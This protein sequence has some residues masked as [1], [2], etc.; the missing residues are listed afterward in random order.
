[1][2]LVLLLL[3]L[4]S[5]IVYRLLKFWILDP[6]RIHRDLWSQG[7]PGRYIPVVG[8]ILHIRKRI[9]AE[10]PFSHGRA[11]ATRS[12]DY[13]HISFGPIARF[14]TF[15]PALMNG[16]LK[17]NAHAYHKPYIMQMIL[18][19]LLGNDS[20]LMSED[21]VHARH[22][23]LIAP[24]FQHQNVNSMISLMAEIT[25]NLITK[26]AVA[27]A[28]CHK[29]EP[30]TLNIREEMARLTLDNVSVTSCVFGTEIISDE[31]I[32]ETIYRGA[33]ETLELVE[34]RTFNMIGII[35]II[36]RLPF[37]GKPH[38]DKCNR[39]TKEIIRRIVDERKKGL[40]KSACKG[41]RSCIGQNFAMLEAKIMLA[42]I[43]RRFRFELEPGQKYVPDVVI[44]MRLD[45]VGLSFNL[46]PERNREYK[47]PL[48]HSET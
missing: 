1:M 30:F 37:A 25:S 28:A 23:R 33:T 46:E 38:I 17:T 19:V 20:L 29:D 39:E 18:G 24:V 42:L 11:L 9:L 4:I 40:T 26:W 7:V 34:K 21:E 47:F 6:W 3:A 10:D 8:E 13:Y 15:D 41:P 16:V 2:L 5:W 27:A 43:I 48:Y 32:H 36:N 22:R 12:G 31:T 35:P 44:T 14:E 45:A